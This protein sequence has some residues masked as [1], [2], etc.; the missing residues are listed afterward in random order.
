MPSFG[1]SL[2]AFDQKT[3]RK[4]DKV[5]QDSVFDLMEACQTPQPSVEQTG[6][7][8]EEGKIPV[9]SSDLIRS[10]ATELNGRGFSVPDEFSYQF[11]IAQSKAGDTMRFWWTARY[12]LAIE[13]GWQTSAGNEVGG[14]K[15][16]SANAQNWG[17]IVADNARRLAT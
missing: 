7:S 6:G 15:F 2:E 14:R 17:R 5:W 16:V 9:K 4:L 11:T 12:A 10:L 8:Y 13:L 1:A 3:T